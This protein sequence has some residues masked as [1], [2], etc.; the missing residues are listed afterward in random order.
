MGLQH[1]AVERSGAAAHCP[2]AAAV[3][4]VGSTSVA[5]VVETPLGSLVAAGM[6]LLEAAAAMKWVAMVAVALSSW[7]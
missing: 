6:P 3:P 5:R 4:A 1:L 2:A 7:V